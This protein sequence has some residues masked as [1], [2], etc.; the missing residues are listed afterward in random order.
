MSKAAGLSTFIIV[1]FIATAI[2]ASACCMA[3]DE[4]NATKSPEA[5][6]N[7]SKGVRLRCE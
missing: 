7:V 2:L 3:A 4:P 1:S 5:G 6:V